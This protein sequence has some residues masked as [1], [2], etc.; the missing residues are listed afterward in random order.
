MA[1]R[2]SPQKPN[3]SKQARQSAR[4]REPSR[5]QSW[6]RD[7]RS[8]EGGRDRIQILSLV[9]LVIGGIVT[10]RLF[11]VQILDHGVYEALATGQHELIQQ[12][13]PVRGE[14]LAQDPFAPEGVS[15]IATNQTLSE[16][17]ANPKQLADQGA[18]P[19]KTAELLTPLLGIP[20][21]E[22]EAK[23]AKPD[24]PY[25][26]LVHKASDQQVKA[27]KE[28]ELAGIH[29]KD[30][31]WRYYPE[32]SAAAQITGFVGVQDDVR[33]GQYGIEGK[34][35]TQLAGKV[36][37]L[38]TE[39]DSSGRFI[40]VGDR[41]LDPAQDGDTFVL[42]IDKNVQ[43]AV[44]LKVKA[45]AEKHGADQAA[46]I[47]MDPNTGYIIAM[48]SYP[49][50]DPNDYGQVE[51][52]DAYINTVVSKPYEVGSIMKPMTMSMAIDQGK[53][54]PETTYTDSGLVE[55]GGFK[56]RNSDGKANGVQTMIDVL[57]KSLNTGAIFAAQQ[58]GVDTFQTYMK[59][60]GFGEY[61]T[62]ELPY[63]QSGDISALEK[64]KEIYMATASYGQGVTTTMLQMATAYSVLANGGNLVEPHII[65]EIRKA[66]G[67]VEYTEPAVVRRVIQQS[68][69]TTVAA[70]LVS[71]V[72]NGHGQR[73][74]LPGYYVAGK[75]GT[76]QVPKTD[77]TGYDS[78]THIGSFAGFFP[79]SNPQ[80]VIVTRLDNPKDV[81]FAES[82]AAP[83]FA[84]IGHFL[85][86]YYHV[87]PD[88]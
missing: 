55:I 43:Y 28:L 62:I 32:K 25:E 74:Q 30:E 59:N 46:T 26:P 16:V 24:D 49:D 31:S 44:C 10:V 83:L 69:A 37:Q 86:N 5:G 56:I 42:S 27:I 73:A 65:T 38:K 88:R 70:M 47:I 3:R 80:F 48:C 76:A 61:T 1:G 2:Y 15:A 18:D 6:R 82:S 12:L 84:E 19:A 21:A 36:G 85:I 53:V 78:N 67:Y 79:V 51:S 41:L 63:E 9:F 4:S 14:I 50:F 45:A 64:K 58:V 66:N 75:T 39:L 13:Y 17:Y 35:N 77:G 33:V 11:V 8:T 87:A 54:T 20:Q 68:T 57:D 81:Q 22:L 34:Y 72:E 71:V 60:Y 52:I 29:F 40:A 7:D 23:L